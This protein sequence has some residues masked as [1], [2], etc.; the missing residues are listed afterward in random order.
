MMTDSSSVSE[1]EETVTNGE[2]LFREDGEPAGVVQRV[3]GGTARVALRAGFTGDIDRLTSTHLTGEAEL[4][5]RCT[6]CGEMDA[7]GG[8]LPE[9]CPACGARREDLAYWTED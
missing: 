9:A 1:S 2:T 4:L 7:I 6:R 5:W 8:G 3:E